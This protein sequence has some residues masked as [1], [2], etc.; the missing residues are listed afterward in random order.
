MKAWTFTLTV[1]FTPILRS[2]RSSGHITASQLVTM[3]VPVALSPIRH[4]Y[5]RV[6]HDIVAVC[7]SALQSTV[8]EKAVVHLLISTSSMNPCANPLNN[9]CTVRCATNKFW[10]LAQSTPTLLRSS[11][12][13]RST[14]QR[15]LN[16]R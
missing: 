13:G 1:T 6:Y 12:P 3:P 4:W 2:R 5:Y 15:C 8:K 11:S 7:T 9:A 10:S 16:D 14:T